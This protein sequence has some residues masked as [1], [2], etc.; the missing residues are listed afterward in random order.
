MEL[1]FVY[2]K[3]HKILKDFDASFSSTYNVIFSDSLL[4][5]EHKKDTTVDYYSGCNLKAIVGKN[6]AGKSTLLDFIEESCSNYTESRGFIIWYDSGNKSFLIH[7]INETL[8]SVRI[9]SHLGYKIVINN[10]RS[11]EK[12]ETKIFKINNMATTGF[13]GFNKKRKNVIDYSLGAQSKY[14]GK[15][16]SINLQR[17]LSFFNNSL[18]LK[19]KKA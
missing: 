14:R 6:G 13:N 19:N 16:R 9:E 3:E 15:K 1:V 18:W 7:D 12:T 10:K 2:A 8:K 11:L 17:M 5:I 4:S